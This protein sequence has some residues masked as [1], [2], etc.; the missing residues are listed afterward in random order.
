MRSCRVAPGVVLT[1]CM[2]VSSL[3]AQDSRPAE[4][5]QFEAT[6]AQLPRGN[7]AWS[8]RVVRSGGFMGQ[9]L[10]LTL[11]S[12]GKLGCISCADAG[13]SRTLSNEALVAVAPAFD[14]R[15]LLVSQSTV[16]VV[17]PGQSVALDLSPWCRDC[18]VTRITV[19]HR[20]SDGKVKTYA[21]SWDD[22]TAAGVPVDLVKLA[23]SI[24][25]L[26]K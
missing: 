12:E 8:V 18:F 11:T 20:D 26:V 6:P 4:A 16:K 25:S 2:T 22:V 10:T 13:V 7:N 3:T 5:T 14:P 9:M 23:N 19:Q 17:K 21:A 1:L 24:V 15:A